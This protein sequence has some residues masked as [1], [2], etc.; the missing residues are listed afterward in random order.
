LRSIM[1]DRNH[2]SSASC[3]FV[4]G[5]ENGLT[6]IEVIV[7]MVIVMVMVLGV[8]SSIPLNES[9]QVRM[10]HKSMGE[11]IIDGRVDSLFTVDFDS[12]KSDTAIVPISPGKG[13]TAA[14][15]LGSLFVRV[16][17]IDHQLDGKGVD[18]PGW[19]DTTDIKRIILEL[20]WPDING[21]QRVGRE[22]MRANPGP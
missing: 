6:L 7:S 12:V 17:N 21:W 19:P 15:L 4:D 5:S 14:S 20:K 3:R 22:T 1:N 11:A 13:G 9:L 2:S 18:D 10:I 16:Q 8:L